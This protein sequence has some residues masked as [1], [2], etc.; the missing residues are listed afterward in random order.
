MSYDLAV[1][2]GP[3]PAT[4]EG[5][6]RDFIRL[7]DLS[8]ELRDREEQPPPA[9]EL[10]AYAA[11]AAERFPVS[12]EDSP[13]AGWPLEQDIVGDLLSLY[14]T[15]SG[16]GR[17]RDVLAELALEM[18]LNCLDPQIGRLLPDPEAASAE[19]V[20]APALAALAEY[21]QKARRRPGLLARILG[22]RD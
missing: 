19:E 14:L 1:W 21:E 11:A 7:M 15:F 12:D 5:A 22:R 3:R 18:G 10:L 9:P 16:A 4:Q 2:V 8:E 13:W 6:E 17:A 20:S